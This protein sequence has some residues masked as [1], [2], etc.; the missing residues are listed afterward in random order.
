MV[1]AVALSVPTGHFGGSLVHKRDFLFKPLERATPPE[2][3]QPGNGDE[4]QQ[5]ADGDGQQPPGNGDAPPPA[6]LSEF[7]REIMPIFD[8][9]MHLLHTP[10]FESADLTGDRD[11]ETKRVE[12]SPA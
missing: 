7:D 9:G 2:Q 4:Q 5:P 6:P 8:F 11:L 1:A 10:L 3:Q 12:Q